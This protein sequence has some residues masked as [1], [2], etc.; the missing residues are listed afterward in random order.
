MANNKIRFV[1]VMHRKESLGGGFAQVED[2]N[3]V[4]LARLNGTIDDYTVYEVWTDESGLEHCDYK[5][6]VIFE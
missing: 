1:Y 6:C 4:I 2:L 5:D 3:E